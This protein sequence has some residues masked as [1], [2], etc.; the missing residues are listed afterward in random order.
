MQ[1]SSLRCRQGVMLPRERRQRCWRSFSGRCRGGRAARAGGRWGMQSPR[2]RQ[3][4]RASPPGRPRSARRGRG[5][6]RAA[7]ARPWARPSR[8]RTRRCPPPPGAQRAQPAKRPAGAPSRHRAMW[9]RAAAAREAAATAQQV[10]KAQQ[11]LPQR[12]D[13]TA[14]FECRILLLNCR[15]HSRRKLARQN[16]F[17]ISKYGLIAV[18]AGVAGRSAPG[19]ARGRNSRQRSMLPEPKTAP[20][21]LT[22]H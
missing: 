9:R 14:E 8:S 22:G 5:A 7:A 6:C 18:Q 21:V 15:D 11:A 10:Q 4:S 13:L 19:R 20:A 12:A 17:D 1:R 16:L 2:P 3:R